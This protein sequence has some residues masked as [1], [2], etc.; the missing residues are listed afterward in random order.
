MKRLLS[1][2][3]LLLITVNSYS[4]DLHIENFIPSYSPAF[5]IINNIS[6]ILSEVKNSE[7]WQEF[8]QREKEND[9]KETKLDKL[10]ELMGIDL[11]NIVGSVSKRVAFVQVDLLSMG[12]PAIIAELS[13]P[14]QFSNQ[15]LSDLKESKQ[16]R[17]NGVDFWSLKN[18]DIYAFVENIFI[19]IH[20]KSAFESLIRIYKFEEASILQEPKYNALIDKISK[21]NEVLIYIN[22]EILNPIIWKLTHNDEMRVFGLYDTKAQLFS[23]NLFDS[24]KAQEIYVLTGNNLLSSLLSNPGTFISP[25]IVPASNS[26]IFCALNIGDPEAMWE[27]FKASVRDV[28]GEE[29][30]AQ[31]QENVSKF[32]S[33]TKLSFKD[34]FLGMLSGEIG[35]AIPLPEVLMPEDDSRFSFGK[36]LMTFYKINEQ[37]KCIET[38][39]KMFSPAQVQKTEYKGVKIQ[40]VPFLKGPEGPVGYI[41]VE[42]MLIFS[43]LKRLQNLIDEEF[44]LIV[45]DDFAQINSS[46]SDTYGMIFFMDLRKF[47]LSIN[48]HLQA[49]DKALMQIQEIGSIGSFMFYDGQEVIIRI[50]GT[51][52]K[53]WLETIG[54]L[55]N[56]LSIQSSGD[57]K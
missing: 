51:Q 18:E 41:C 17:Y 55:M 22:S 38:V 54:N 27:N 52:K 37:S 39:E 34:D 43:S 12:K 57:L 3:I 6:K 33:E 25:H 53:S 42:N 5:I 32:E 23:V 48:P 35:F 49:S 44:P 26:D 10:R 8:I 20:G 36:G 50:Y 29:G 16:E 14:K 13:D 40:Y 47:L 30:Y 1:V 11:W 21:D 7:T 45:S 2:I 4:E 24:K 19:Y 15:I 46:Y 31:L 28:A 56:L 9:I